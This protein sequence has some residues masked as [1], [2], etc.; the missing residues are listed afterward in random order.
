VNWESLAV[1]R[2]D[3]ESGDWDLGFAV[4][5]AAAVVEEVVDLSILHIEG[6]A[7]F[8]SSYE[9]HSSASAFSVLHVTIFYVR[10]F[11]LVF[12]CSPS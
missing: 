2:E 8:R 3:G 1:I 5:A 12:F 7:S 11:V 9:Y 6:A 4:A 10:F